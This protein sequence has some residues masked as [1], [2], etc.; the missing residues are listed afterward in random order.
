MRQFSQLLLHQFFFCVSYVLGAGETYLGKMQKYLS[1]IE[2]QFCFYS[3]LYLFFPTS[4]ELLFFSMIYSGL[5]S[6]FYVEDCELW[7]Y[8]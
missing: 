7:P 4:D 1:L 3:K 2:K 6:A 8:S 5:Q